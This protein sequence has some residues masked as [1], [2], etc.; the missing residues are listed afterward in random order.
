MRIN[1]INK[2]KGDV[3]NTTPSEVEGLN[4]DPLLI[5]RIVLWEYYGDFLS[6]AAYCERIAAQRESMATAYGAA[7]ML[8][9]ERSIERPEGKDHETR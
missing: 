2:N 5:A 8:L 4:L 3:N 7:S 6:A 1:Q 9:R